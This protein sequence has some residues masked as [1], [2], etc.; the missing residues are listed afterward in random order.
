MKTNIQQG[1]IHLKGY[2]KFSVY[3]T[4]EHRLIVDPNQ[5]FL[6]CEAELTFGDNQSFV[7]KTKEITPVTTPPRTYREVTYQGEISNGCHVEYTWPESWWERGEVLH[8]ITGTINTHTGYVFS[9]PGI[10]K[11]TLNFYGYYDGNRFYA[12]CQCSALQEKPGTNPVYSK[13]V[14]GPILWDVSIDLTKLNP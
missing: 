1:T 11:N 8:G 5:F 14:E 2:T 12:D 4:K 10:N 7:L 9:G 6:D 13:A 3:A